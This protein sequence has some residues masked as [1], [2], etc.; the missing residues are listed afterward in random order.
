[1]LKSN[2]LLQV[3]YWVLFW[4]LLLIFIFTKFWWDDR[5]IIFEYPKEKIR[6]WGVKVP[7]DSV[8]YHNKQRFD[9]EFLLNSNNLYQFYLYVK[10]YPIYIP[11]IEKKLVD[12]GIHE[13]IKYLPI[14]ESALRDDVVSSAG[15]AWIWQFVPDTARRYGLKIDEY[16]DERYHFEKSTDAAISYL[17]DLHDIFWDWALVAAAYNRWENG[18][19]RDMQ[20]QN[21]DNYYDLYLNEETSRY[22]FRIMAIK[23]V[24]QS[25]FDKKWVIDKIIWGVYEKPKTELIQVWEIDDINQWSQEN[26]Y[27]YKDIKIL[28][29]WII[30]ESLPEWEWEVEVLIND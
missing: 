20:S 9:K 28:N 12:N 8:D 17:W 3:V 18:L 23:Y 6:F 4:S 13:D 1:M 29:R 22:V 27:N 2:S 14:A 10:R 19:R 11:E 24:M 5:S 21:V 15:A 7:I 26:D 30:G 16:V 25:Y